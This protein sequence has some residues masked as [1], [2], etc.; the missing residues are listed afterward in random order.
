MVAVGWLTEE[1]CE[2]MFTPHLILVIGSSRQATTS[3]VC[4]THRSHSL[5]KIIINFDGDSSRFDRVAG[6]CCVLWK[7]TIGEI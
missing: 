4:V 2:I 7:D 1:C 3:L 5:I 6:N